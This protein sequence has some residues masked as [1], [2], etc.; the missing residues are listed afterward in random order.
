MRIGELRP[1]QL[2]HTF[3]IGSIVDLPQVAMMITGLEDWNYQQTKEIGEERLL[4][5]VR[6][7]IGNQVQKLVFPPFLEEEWQPQRGVFDG[8]ANIGVPVATFPRWLRCPFC[9]LLAP[10]NSGLF[11]LKIDQFR[12]DRT[13]YVHDNCP[14]SRTAPAAL[15][16][17][18]IVACENGHLDDFPWVQ[19]CHYMSPCS[20]PQLRLREW[21]PSGEASDIMVS[22]DSCGESRRMTEAFGEEARN[23]NMPRC[24]ARRPHLRDFEDS[25]EH[26]MKTILLGASNSWFPITL[27]SLSIPTTT[28][29]LFQLIEEHWHNLQKATSKQNIILMEELGILKSFIGFTIDQIWE[30]IEQKRKSPNTTEGDDVTDLKSPEWEV[31]VDPVSERNTTD[32]H[33]TENRPPI[34]YSSQIQ[35]VV[36]VDRLREVS[37]LI[38]FTRIE[39][40]GDFGEVNEIPAE[41]RMPLSRN[42]A[43]FIPAT[44]MR[45]EGIFIRF[46]EDWLQQW[47]TKDQVQLRDMEFR[48]CHQ[49]W[50]RKRNISPPEAFY[51]GMRYVMMHTFSHALM[52]QLSIEC[53]YSAASIRERIYSRDPESGRQPMAGVL[54]YTA[55]SDSEGTLGGLVSLGETNNIERM[56][57]LA[58]ESAGL[59]SSDPLCSEHKPPSDGLTLHG[60]ACHSCL[61][62]PETSCERANKYLDRALLVSTFG[63]QDCGIF[64]G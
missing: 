41:Q 56:I 10:I 4:A 50:R 5:A 40:P 18:F 62:V 43:L 34:K 45:G 35:Q 20:A 12:P 28:N 9:D 47:L 7:Q 27:S 2:I 26:Q 25:C 13:K 36:L 58:L 55:A 24:R 59:C 29:K 37:S 48:S 54:I 1:S 8:S 14:N 31:F 64:T 44:E 17:R 15:P 60:A 63:I 23:K 11:K 52:R 42:P 21:G 32:F 39:S 53:G 19:Y 3:G 16:S 51:P 33:L 22:C 38:G 49:S 46:N 61:F 57:S 30:A 6:S